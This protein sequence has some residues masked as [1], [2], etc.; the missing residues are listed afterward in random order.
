MLEKG[1]FA[2]LFGD[3]TESFSV[4]IIYI[5]CILLVLIA[6]YLLGSINSAIIVSKLLHRD[7]IRNHGSGNAGLTNIMRTYGKK[8]MLLTLT[9]DILKVALS[10]LL[11]GFLF[12]FYFAKALSWN[13][14]CYLSGF[15]CIIG[16]IKPVFYHFKGGKGVLCTFAMLAFLS[17]PIFLA[18]LLLFVLL[19]AM[20]KYISLASIVCAA[21]LPI[22]MQGYMEI[23]AGEGVYNPIIMIICLIIA[24]IV[25]FCHRSNIKR[26]LNGEENKFHFHKD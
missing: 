14:L 9:G 25:V 10:V 24:F 20:T 22:F 12:G 26:L 23:F 17:P 21:F 8:A 11:T 1:L 4:Y 3:I 15:F 16:H 6:S 13:E 5:I 7:D 2:T 19:V 18:L